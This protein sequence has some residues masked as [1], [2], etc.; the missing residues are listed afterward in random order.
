MLGTSMIRRQ[1]MLAAFI[2]ACAAWVPLSAQEA[3][4]PPS[5]TPAGEEQYLIGDGGAGAADAG[6]SSF[7]VWDLV[8]MV[9]VLALVAGAA[10]GALVLIRRR[11]GTAAS[12]SGS[13]IRVLETRSLGGNKAVHL[14]ALQEEIFLLGSADASVGLIHRVDNP[15]LRQELLVLASNKG[16]TAPA[17]FTDLVGSLFVPKPAGESGNPQEIPGVSGSDEGSQPGDAESPDGAGPSG[18]GSG[19]PDLENQRDRLRRL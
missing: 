16:R 1:A 9:L 5:A 14:V 8:R 12:E 4:V 10:Y 18:E 17:S 13:L 6:G 19:S 3:S 2:L 15:D 11:Q 7:G